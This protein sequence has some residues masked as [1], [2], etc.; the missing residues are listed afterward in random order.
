MND[1]TTSNPL[2]DL[3]VRIRSEYEKAR[4]S[5]R[6]SI[7]HALRVGELLLEAKVLVQHGEW[8]G[9]LQRNCDLSE[10]M[11]QGYMRLARHLRDHPNTKLVSD[12]DLTIKDALKA[13][14]KPKQTKPPTKDPAVVAA[15][16]R[17]E[18][19]SETTG[20]PT[21][22][23]CATSEMPDIPA[24][25]RRPPPLPKPP[26]ITKP[27]DPAIAEAVERA[28]AWSEESQRTQALII[29]S[30]D[31]AAAQFDEVRR[32][33]AFLIEDQAKLLSG[34]QQ[35]EFLLHLRAVI[36]GLLH[37]TIATVKTKTAD[38]ASAHAPNIDAGPTYAIAEEDADHV[39]L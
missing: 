32:D 23:G 24:F 21:S 10:R 4:Q 38:A 2:P 27:K 25:L 16:D 8:S 33:F 15:A 18:A 7:E 5:A 30:A 36:D 28:V 20:A 11:A 19:R 14:A 22:T 12:L 6:A 13:L 37:D 34:K 39:D 29:S 3:A 1:L 35:A 9:W 31:A 26:T 17:A